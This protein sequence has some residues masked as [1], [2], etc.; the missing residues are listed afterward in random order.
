MRW[1]GAGGGGG[2]V[3]AL[4]YE[5]GG[6]EEGGWEGV[7]FKMCWRCWRKDTSV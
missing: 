1:G 4:L 3:R 6:D 5:R 7:K 2:T